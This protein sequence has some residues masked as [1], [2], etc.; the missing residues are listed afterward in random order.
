MS[1]EEPQK[2]DMIATRPDSDE[3]RLVISDHLDWRDVQRHSLRLQEKLNTYIAFVESGQVHDLEDPK[4]PVGSRITIVVAAQEQPPPESAAFFE[5]VAEI[6]SGIGIG[7]L[8][9]V[10]T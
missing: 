2:I 1:V 8:V 5:Q 6:L 3:V 4:V 9:Q 7:F 10:H